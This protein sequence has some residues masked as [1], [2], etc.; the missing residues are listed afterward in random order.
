MTDKVVS[1]RE[2]SKSD[3]IQVTPNEA[4]DMA[5]KEPSK[6]VIIIM[7]DEDEGLSWLQGGSIPSG[8][9]VWY[10]ER[11]KHDLISRTS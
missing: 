9:I 8:D 10:V 4:L 5:K 6:K 7:I 11:V 3:Y 1:L 2:A